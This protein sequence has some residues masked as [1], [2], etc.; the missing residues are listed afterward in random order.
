[1]EK[2]IKQFRVQSKRRQ[3]CTFINKN[4]RHTKVSLLGE[5]SRYGASSSPAITPPFEDMYCPI[6]FHLSSSSPSLG[7]PSPNTKEKTY[8]NEHGCSVWNFHFSK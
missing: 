3:S 2:S 6:S 4:E 5:T 7:S 1:L 8:I